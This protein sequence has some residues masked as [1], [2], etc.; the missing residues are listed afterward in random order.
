MAAPVE[1]RRRKKRNNIELVKEDPYQG[2][3]LL[4]G[5]VKEAEP[6]SD[7]EV[8]DPAF[9]ADRFNENEARERRRQLLKDLA[10]DSMDPTEHLMEE[11][12]KIRTQPSERQLKSEAFKKEQQDL[13]SSKSSGSKDSAAGDRR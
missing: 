9:L 6:Q 5:T 8:I 3:P 12:E 13:V 4:S 1:N 10:A 7:D 2:K 11:V